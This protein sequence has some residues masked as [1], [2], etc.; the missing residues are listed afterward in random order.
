VSSL[1]VKA[2][3]SGLAK[4]VNNGTTALAIGIRHR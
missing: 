2:R 4:P 3:F 1:V